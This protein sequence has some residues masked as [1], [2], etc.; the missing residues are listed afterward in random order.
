MSD[1]PATT[2][3]D[4]LEFDVIIVGGGC[5]GLAAATV[6]AR[7][8]LNTIVLERGKPGNKNVMG[9][10]LYTRSTADVYG[11]FWRDAPVERHVLE[12]NLWVLSPD[13]AIKIGYRSQRFGDEPANAFTVLRARMDQ[14][15][16]KQAGAAGALI[17]P[18]T[19]VVEA[20][21]DGNR[22][23]GVRTSRPDGD[24]YAPVTIIC[25]G[26]N[27]QLTQQLGMQ[28]EIDTNDM[29]SCTKEV[30]AFPPEVIQDRFHVRPGE[31]V[32]I[33]LFGDS[34]AGMLGMAWIYT[35]RDTISLG[36]GVGL[37]DSIKSDIT[38]HDML[39]RL[40][41]H[42]MVAPLID[43][44]QTREYSSHM[45]PEGGWRKLPQ[46]YGDGVMVCGDAAMLVNAV[47]REGSN[48]ATWSGKLAAETAI[49]AHEKGDFGKK[50]L[51]H[52]YHHL[53]K[54]VPTL[55]DLRK[56]R[57]AMEFPARHRSVLGTYPD[58]ASY[59]MREMLTVDGATKRE[60][61]FRILRQVLRARSIFGYAYDALESLRMI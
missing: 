5:A 28:G 26:V 47:H 13:S 24:V 7:A 14:W 36:V 34:S 32:T 46:L 25:E 21:R 39:Q 40:K 38:P 6:C 54:D 59:A 60:K 29:S 58:L 12:Q 55:Q 11:E 56:Y 57:Y 3:P 61:E 9:G 15:F 10:V 1:A 50:T 41:A 33:E 8:G 31:G 48:H 27:P 35:N 30:I 37:E 19:S 23:V 52:Y 43:G 22:V 2:I 17:V 42:P 53:F 44:G 16:A 49:H 51:A 20:I 45:I 4:R 18:N